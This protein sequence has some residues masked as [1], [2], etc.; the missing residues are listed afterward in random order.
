MKVIRVTCL[1]VLAAVGAQGAIF[2]EDWESGLD[3]QTWSSWGWPSPILST[4]NH[5]QGT[6]SLDPNGDGSYLSG[7]ISTARFTPEVGMQLSVQA[8]IESAQSWSE[9]EFGL[10][11]ATQIDSTPVYSEYNYVTLF[12]D[13]DQQGAGP[14]M[15]DYYRKGQGAASNGSTT[16][17]NGTPLT[18][19]FD[20]WH[21]FTFTFTE[22]QAIEIAI[23]GVVFNAS[24]ENW[25][26][27]STDEFSIYLGGRSYGVTENLYD[28]IELTV[29]PE[30]STALLMGITAGGI[31][32]VR[33]K[34]RV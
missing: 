1:F 3:S 26:D 8:Y 4:A 18:S 34:W 7:V 17:V 15:W 16:Q 31:M 19:L 24:P 21:T 13:A 6:Y 28:Q 22:E 14:Q 30:P 10:A 11:A 12:I 25:Y 5:R 2:T 23:D 20:G 33:R 9:L 27:A 32:I 29:I